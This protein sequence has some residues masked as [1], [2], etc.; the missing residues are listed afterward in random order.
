M[1]LS[2]VL[3]TYNFAETS[4]HAVRLAHAIARKHGARLT[5]VYVVE[6]ALDHSIAPSGRMSKVG[7]G[8][9]PLV[10]LERRL[11]DVVERICADRAFDVVIGH[12]SAA[13]TIL[14]LSHTGRYDLVLMARRDQAA[15]DA[16]IGSVCGRVVMDA[17]CPA[18]I[19]TDGSGAGVGTAGEFAHPLVAVSNEHLAS[20]ALTAT[21]T[22]LGRNSR[23]NLLH[24]QETYRVPKAYKVLGK[25]HAK[26][27][28]HREHIRHRLRR[29]AERLERAGLSTSVRSEAGSV[30]ACLRRHVQNNPCDLIVVSR[31][32]PPSGPGCLS[33][34]AY[35]ILESSPVPVLIVPC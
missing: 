7:G 18:V 19:T 26:I 9:A 28:E 3:V 30:T 14:Q 4:P 21:M 35:S 15:G 34:F 32:S 27:Q 29:L 33:A 31:R 6:T 13:K 5:V 2:S 22:L 20:G 12:G 1:R 23:V 25:P 16:P 10:G 24:V 11:H 8:T 17:G